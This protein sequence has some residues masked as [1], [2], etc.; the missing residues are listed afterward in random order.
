MT[1]ATTT[2]YVKFATT[3][4]LVL[5]GP[6]SYYT[7]PK[8]IGHVSVMENGI[9][10]TDRDDNDEFTQLF[11]TD[12]VK[13][14]RS[15][16]SADNNDVYDTVSIYLPRLSSTMFNEASFQNDIYQIDPAAKRIRIFNV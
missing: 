7:Q 5:E 11:P 16:I 12:I 14:I 3:S 4:G 6:N 15:Y 8:D 9:V 10:I 2:A 1:T 13:L